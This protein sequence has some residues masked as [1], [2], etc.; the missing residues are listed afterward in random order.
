[1]LYFRKCRNFA[2]MVILS[3]PKGP[4]CN[5]RACILYH[6]LDFEWPV[7]M[8]RLSTALRC[9]EDPLAPGGG[10]HDLCNPRGEMQ[11][12]KP[13]FF[14]LA[15]TARRPRDAI[16]VVKLQ[17]AR[18]RALHSMS[19]PF[20]YGQ[21]NVRRKARWA[22]MMMMIRAYLRTRFYEACP[23]ITVRRVDGR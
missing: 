8:S 14:D 1:M 23:S 2:V 7:G 19:P 12:D 6:L 9:I 20:R 16:K 21:R 17:Y 5:Q 10:R 18:E 11:R 15:V 4:V 3:L 13:R 22:R